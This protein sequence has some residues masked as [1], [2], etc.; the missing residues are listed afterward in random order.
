M[1]LNAIVSGDRAPSSASVCVLDAPVEV[2]VGLFGGAV[3]IG[4]VAAAAAR[5]WRSAAALSTPA[6]AARPRSFSLFRSSCCL[7]HRT[8]SSQEYVSPVAAR[9]GEG[10]GLGEW[11]GVDN[12]EYTGLGSS[13][14]DGGDGGARDW[15][16]AG[17]E[18]S[19]LL[20]S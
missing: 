5:S 2:V 18:G 15:C 1:L 13:S 19:M 16:V 6:A 20:E 10:G 7:L 4:A 11:D 9:G 14:R 17:G 8:R 3:V 12:G